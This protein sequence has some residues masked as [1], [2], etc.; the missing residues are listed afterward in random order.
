MLQ[1]PRHNCRNRRGIFI[2]APWCGLNAGQ[3]II[4]NAFFAKFAFGIIVSGRKCVHVVRRGEVESVC[5]KQ[6]KE[7]VMPEYW[8]GGCG[9]ERQISLSV[10]TE[11]V[12]VPPRQHDFYNVHLRN[13]L[14]PF[15]GQS[16]H[17]R[18]VHAGHNKRYVVS[19]RYSTSRSGDFEMRIVWRNNQPLRDLV[20]CEF[21]EE[22][23]Q[24]FDLNARHRVFPDAVMRIWLDDRT[25]FFRFDF[26]H[27]ATP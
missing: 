16:C 14:D 15:L 19:L 6:A 22:Y 24:I 17:I 23:T 20:R 27:R 2:E 8:D 21:P 7:M 10:F 5:H 12:K 25:D 18:L 11:G 26:Q 4:P 3:N 9:F 13:P 1:H